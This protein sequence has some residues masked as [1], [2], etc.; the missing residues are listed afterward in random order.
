MQTFVCF[1]CFYML[2]YIQEINYGKVAYRSTEI[3]PETG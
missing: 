2:K 3:Q 1:F